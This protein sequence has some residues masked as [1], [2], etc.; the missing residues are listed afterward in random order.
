MPVLTLLEAINQ[1]LHQ[2]MEKDDSVFVIGQ[3]VGAFGGAFKATAGLFEKFGR[4]RV[5]D[6]PMCEWGVVGLANGAALMGIRPVVEIQFA[7]FIST[8]FDTIVQYSATTYYRWGAPIPIVVRAP[9]G[10]GSRAGPFHSQ[11]PEAWFAHT[12]GLKVVIPSNP[13]DAKGLLISAIRDANPVVFF[14]P[15]Y[16]YRRLKGDVPEEPYTVPLGRA[17][18]LRE[19]GDL[20][21]ITYG[22]MVHDAL[23]ATE[24]LAGD[25]IHCEVIDLRTVSPLDEETILRSVEKTGRLLVLHEARRSC[26]IGSEVTALVSEK[27]FYALDAPPVRLTAPDTPVPFS[28]PLEDAYR[29]S[30]ESVVKAARELVGH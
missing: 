24:T 14:E 28:P 21:I 3:D 25:G 26:G 23:S 11:C 19:A 10:G 29:P 18:V 15:K 1:A 7:D 5:I 12:A 2:E 27:A 13:Y 17:A 16:L 20:T 4:R 6:T 9:W 30:A 8:A 22:A